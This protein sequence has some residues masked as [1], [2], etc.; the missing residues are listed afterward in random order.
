M[1]P[2][3]QARQNI[4]RQLDACGW[5]VQSRRAMN[6]YAAMG[7]A[8]REFVMVTGEADY[9]LYVGGKA[10]GV[11]EAKPPGHPLIGVEGQSAKY[12]RACRPVFPLPPPG[13]LL[14]RKHRGGDAVHQPVGTRCAAV[15]CLRLPSPRR[16]SPPRPT[17]RQVRGQVENFPALEVSKLWSV[18][19]RAIENLE[20]SLAQNNPRSLI[21]MATGSAKPSPPSTR[22]TGSSSSAG[23]SGSCSSWIGAISGDRPI[24]SSS[25]S[26]AP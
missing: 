9:L 24:G 4:D 14:L 12:V 21:Q 5:L 19:I 7:V 3:E 10:I 13:P 26:S 8:V 23:P 6:I 16:T 18:Q 15:A 20:Q 2:E 17:R 11:V 25:S 1:T 22:A